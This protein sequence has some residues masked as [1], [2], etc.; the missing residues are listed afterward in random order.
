MKTIA[1]WW[2]G[3]VDAE[4]EAL[5][6]RVAQRRAGWGIGTVTVTGNTVNYSYLPENDPEEDAAQVAAANRYMNPGVVREF[7]GRWQPEPRQG[8]L[9]TYSVEQG[10]SAVARVKGIP[11]KPVLTFYCQRLDGED[12][13]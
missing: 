7:V 11:S 3:P 10:P 12:H 1:D 13:W 5:V 6:E 8:A 9:H 2:Y 4:T